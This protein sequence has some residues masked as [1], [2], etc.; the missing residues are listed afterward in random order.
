[1]DL[2]RGCPYQ[3]SFC[4]I[5]NV[6][7]RKSRFRSPDDLEHAIRKRE[8]PLD[9]LELFML[10]PLPGSEDHKVLWQQ[11]TWMDSDLNKY[12]LNNRAT[13][14]PVMSD[15]DWDGAYRAAWQSFYSW[16]MCAR[17][18]GVRQLTRGDGRT[19]H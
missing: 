1:L 19:R 14:H 5:I 9:V 2:G 11:G 15:E 6:Q 3:C 4:T 13:H 10:T 12:D 16:S 17:S 18:C 8:L 7:G